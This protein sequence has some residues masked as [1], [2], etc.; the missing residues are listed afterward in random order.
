MP[1]GSSS[2]NELVS[3]NYIV[4]RL[5]EKRLTIMDARNYE[6]IKA[7][8]K[9]RKNDEIQIEIAKRL[10][11]IPNHYAEILAEIFPDEESKSDFIDLYRGRKIESEYMSMFFKKGLIKSKSKLK[12]PML[13]ETGRALRDI[14][15]KEL[16]KP[17]AV[18][19]R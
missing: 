12:V 7:K 19:Y 18:W 16:Y 4:K 3:L 2:F 5:R 10:D 6:R 17:L 9:D 11:E 8:H 14:I 13:T 15:E 1:R